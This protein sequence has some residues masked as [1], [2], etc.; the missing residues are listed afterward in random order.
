MTS[1]AGFDFE[2]EQDSSNPNLFEGFNF[3]LEQS[4]A[5]Q[6]SMFRKAVVQPAAGAVSGFL[7]TPGSIVDLLGMGITWVGN[8]LTGGDMDYDATREAVKRG[9]LPGAKERR[10]RE[11]E[12]LERLQG[13]QSGRSFW[14]RWADLDALTSDDIAPEPFV[15]PNI[16]EVGEG[17]DKVTG[18]YTTPQGKEERITRQG[19]EFV[20]AAAFPIGTAPKA[21]ELVGAGVGGLLAGGARE[22]GAGPLAELGI[23]I[24]GTLVG[25]AGARGAQALPKIAKN[26]AEE[27]IKPSAAKFVSNI[28]FLKVK[29]DQIRKD[30]VKAAKELDLD[31]PLSA[32][33]DNPTLQML[34]TTLAESALSG[35]ALKTARENLAK[36]YVQK[37]KSTIEKVSETAFENRAEAGTAIKN[38]LETAQSSGRETITGLYETALN[39]IPEADT[40]KTPGLLG[41]T[42]SIIKRLEKTLRPSIE[43]SRTLSILKEIEG[44]LVDSKGNL[45]PI[46]ADRLVGFKRSL[47]DTIDF[48]AQGGS[49]KLLKAVL[50][51]VKKEINNYGKQNP[52]FF[53]AYRLAE[54]SFAQFSEAFRNK[55]ISNALKQQTPE[56]LLNL[57]SQPSKIQ[58]LEEALRYLP[59]EVSQKALNDFRRAKLEELLTNQFIMEKDAGVKYQTASNVFN[60]PKRRQLIRSIAGE[61]TYQDLKRLSTV[62]DGITKGFKRFANAS[63]S[64]VRAVDIGAIMLTVQKFAT[65]LSKFDFGS[66]AMVGG[67]AAS[68]RLIANLMADQKFIKAMVKLGEAGNGKSPVAF[69]KALDDV[70]RPLRAK[71]QQFEGREERPSQ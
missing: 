58:K 11:F 21:A 29:P 53:N 59:E 50:G 1:F 68:P 33:A 30:V 64:G 45:K 65:A 25:G 51:D 41:K 40:I 71:M 15:L 60:D 44:G 54:D 38:A 47:N 52:E 67:L 6:S 46:N 49:K 34:E 10:N 12:A 39:L 61:E 32:I 56:S 57:G 48:E 69:Y 35:N 31:L 7:G 16:Q 43:E 3:E 63:G 27:G 22:A 20:G 66:A 70:I 9:D 18:G 5:P 36:E 24:G 4:P 17:I 28:P 23:A 19:G 62:A 55:E 13:D 8:K 14:E 42:R 26:V 37:F 2:L